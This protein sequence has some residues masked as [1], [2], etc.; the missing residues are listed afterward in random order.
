MELQNN[1]E[2]PLEKTKRSIS[3]RSSQKKLKDKSTKGGN[4]FP[5][6]LLITA[7]EKKDTGEKKVKE[8]E[9]KEKLKKGTSNKLFFSFLRRFLE[10]KAQENGV[11]RFVLHTHKLSHPKRSSLIGFVALALLPSHHG[12]IFLVHLEL[13]KTN[14][15]LAKGLSQLLASD[16]KYE[17]C[18]F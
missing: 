5:H 10:A 7:D 16:G 1:T 15:I 8:K 18:T 3:F 4:F 2:K 14:E 9:N 13:V 11:T 17:K 6:A 12:D